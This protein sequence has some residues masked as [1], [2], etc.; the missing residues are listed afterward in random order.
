[1]I[2]LIIYLI[3]VVGIGLVIYD[4]DVRIMF[5]AVAL[6]FLFISMFIYHKAFAYVNL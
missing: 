6:S 5:Y 1:M 2:I 3:A 4:H